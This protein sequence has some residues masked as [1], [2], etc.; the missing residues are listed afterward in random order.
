[1]DL[2]NASRPA[3]H[4]CQASDTERLIESK[5]KQGFLSLV[6][7]FAVVALPLI[8]LALLSLISGNNCFAGQPIWSDEI[9]YWRE[10]Y[11]FSNYPDGSFGYYGFYGY[12]APVGSWGCH[13]I[14]PLLVYGVP[15]LVFG[16]SANS[17]VICNVGF[18][19]T[20]FFVLVCVLRP[21]HLQCICIIVIWM[22]YMPIM[23][24]APSSMMEL[25]EYACMILYMTFLFV[26]LRTQRGERTNRSM[27]LWA[28]AVVC[29]MSLLRISNIVFFLP[30]VLVISDFGIN[31]RFILSFV[32]FIVISGCL[33]LFSAVF[34]A[35]YPWSFLSGLFSSASV[36]DASRLLISHFFDSIMRF[37][38]FAEDTAQDIQR[39]SYLLVILVCVV[40]AGILLRKE[41]QGGGCLFAI[42]YG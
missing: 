8:Q 3:V 6:L 4:A 1:M 15:S 34:M 22:L 7:Y 27:L 39:Y 13:G 9:D 42:L 36:L 31:K 29:F 12:P 30:L 25:P 28:F 40:F 35:G 37:V 2:N 33:Y 38:S 11:S 20:A 10:I 17:I 32:L 19:T 41:R 21:S 24:Y 14:A 18:C 23:I 26:A 5:R 16:W